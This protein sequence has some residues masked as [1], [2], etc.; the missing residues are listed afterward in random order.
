LETLTFR[1]ITKQ[2]NAWLICTT[3]LVL[4]FA[5]KFA[6]AKYYA[7]AA[8]PRIRLSVTALTLMKVSTTT[9]NP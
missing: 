6:T 7:A 3:G 1:K 5:R 8:N 4:A 9:K 2:H